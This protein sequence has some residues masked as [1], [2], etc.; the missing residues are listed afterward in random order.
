MWRIEERTRIKPKS[1]CPILAWVLPIKHTEIRPDDY[2]EMNSSGGGVGNPFEPIHV[3]IYGSGLVERDT[4]ETVRGD[5]FGCPLRES[6]KTIRIAP[7]SAKDL[8]TRARDGGFC[9]LCAVYQYPG[10]VFDAGNE[11]LKLSLHGKTKSVWDHDGEPPPIFGEL[12]DSI[13]KLSDIERVA[14][15]RRF[16]P[17]R[18]AEC[19]RIKDERIYR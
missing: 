16:A 3:R 15:T 19:K 8:L 5:T 12:S 7:A 18:E 9:R 11:E 14:D 2:I 6:D 1:N 13:W 17:D 10:F 4:V